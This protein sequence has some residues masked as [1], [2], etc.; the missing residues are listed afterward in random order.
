M[1]VCVCLCLELGGRGAQRLYFNVRV[2][3]HKINLVRV[4]L[5]EKSVPWYLY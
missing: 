3:A 5:L 2:E 1:C 4:P